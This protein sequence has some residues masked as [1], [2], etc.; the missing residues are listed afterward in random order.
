MNPSEPRT[1][2]KSGLGRGL[3]ALIPSGDFSLETP[4]I[5]SATVPGG[6]QSL[7]IADISRNPRQPRSQ[8]DSQELGELA[9][10]IRENGILQPLIVTRS[11]LPGKYTL[12]AG[13][14]RLLA[15]RQAGLERV[16]VILR[17]ASEQQRLELALIE[18]VQRTDLSPLDAAEAYRQLTE[19]FSLS[20][21]QIA[22][23][24]G[25]SRVTITNTLRLLKLPENVRQSLTKGEISEGHARALLG[26]PTPQAQSAALGSILKHELN[27]RQTE[28]LVRKLLG[29]R[30][31]AQP[32]PAPPP[33]I[34]SLEERLR[35]R[36][37]TRVNL[38]PRKR[39]GTLVIHYYSDEELN[40][41]I[42][43]LLG[44]GE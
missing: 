16:P 22:Q 4:E 31:P 24:L 10:S 26:L 5:P 28:E 2:K 32:K 13:E 39:G 30:P 42:E 14:R 25:K 37:G 34:S 18:N 21:E 38:N 15:A 29:Q 23:R 35:Q 11:P 8:I 1:T 9:A 33:E 7:P 6:L 20:H 43:R 19:D 17:D 44:K 40:A 12:I 36:L 41:L 27:V 3:D